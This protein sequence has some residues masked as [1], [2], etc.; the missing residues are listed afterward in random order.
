MKGCKASEECKNLRAISREHLRL[1]SR[2]AD[3]MFTGKVMKRTGE[4]PSPVLPYCIGIPPTDKL[5]T[6]SAKREKAV[7]CPVIVVAN[8]VLDARSMRV[9][10][11]AGCL[12]AS[13]IDW[14]AAD[15]YVSVGNRYT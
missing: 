14:M 1:R 11:K 2:P 12:S 15:V 8:I 10:T 7:S 3:V 5:D 4:A 9:A 13:R 6:A